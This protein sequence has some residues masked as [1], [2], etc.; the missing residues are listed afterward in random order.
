MQMLATLIA[1]PNFD[2]HVLDLA[3][4][5]TVDAGDAGEV[6]DRG[7]RAAYQARLR[8]LREDLDEA[9]ARN[10]LGRR[11]RLEA[12]L[13]ALTAQLAG[14]YGMGGRERRSGAAVERARQNV[15][16]RIA[17]AMHRIAEACPAIGRHL[18]VAVRTG[19]TCVYQ[20]DR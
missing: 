13:D 7:A 6:I 12:E 4:A 17:D 1:N 18:D 19:T 10:D 16:R 14:A 5:E 15:R 11:E 9:E 2:H 8:E 3:G 20:P